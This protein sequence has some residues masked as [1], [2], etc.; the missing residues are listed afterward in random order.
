MLFRDGLPEI[1]P[2]SEDGVFK[3]TFTRK[4][5][6]P[7]LLELLSDILS[8]LLKDV[9]VRNNEPPINDIDAKREVFD[10]NCVA[11]DDQAQM[12]IEIQTTPMKGDTRENEH[13]SFRNRAVFYLSDLHANQ[14]G[15]GIRYADFYNS[16]QIMIC[17]YKVFSWDNELVEKFTYRNERGRQLSDITAAVFIDLTQADEIAKKPVAEM[18]GIELWV[19]FLAKAN[20]PEYRDVI[21]EIIKRKEGISVAYEMLTSISAD[22]NERARFRSRRMWQ[23]DREHEIASVNYEWEKIVADK[24]AI[25]AELRAKLDERA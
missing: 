5:A 18:T 20:D 25:I 24:D 12:D 16:Y 11:S 1:L 4:E 21:N 15:R 19:V 6:K 14:P 22:E 23:M 8:R 2:P 13:K 9:A 3:S 7:A 10:I 17:N